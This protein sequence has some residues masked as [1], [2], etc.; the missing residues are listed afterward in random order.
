M[1]RGPKMALLQY[2]ASHRDRVCALL[3]AHGRALDSSD[4]GTG[5]TYVTA[6]VCAA[7]A[8]RPFVVCPKSVLPTWRQV[9]REFHVPPLGVTN[10]E[11]LQNCTMLD[12]EGGR[13]PCPWLAHY[14]A[15]RA[16]DHPGNTLTDHT[17]AWHDLPADALL[18]FDEAHR[19]K[20]H[21]T[22]SSVLLYT[23]AC[24]DARIL[25]LSA[26]IADKMD[27]FRMAGFVLRLYPAISHALNWMRHAEAANRGVP[28]RGVH[29]RLYP[30]RAARMRIQE[31]G[32]LFP[33]NQVVAQC[34][35]MDAAQEIEAQY[36]IIAHEVTRLR[37]REQAVQHELA[38]ILYARMR[39]EQ[40]KVPCMLELARQYLDEGNAVV[41][42]VNFANTLQVLAEQLGT[43]CTI[44]GDQ[45]L[46]ERQANIDQF[47]SDASHVIVCNIRSGGVG[48]SLH[49]T[50]GR[51]PRVSIINPSWS[52]QDLLQALGRVHRAN[53]R[54]PVRQ[55]IV[56]CANTVEEGVCARMREKVDNIVGLND[57][58]LGACPLNG[59]FG[60]ADADYPHDAPSHVERVAEAQLRLDGLRLQV[61]DAERELAALSAAA[62]MP[63]H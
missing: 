56:F 32:A 14:E 3:T 43:R 62:G 44:S 38:R 46:E 42:F 50:H 16:R 53:G 29:A 22:V 63:D 4:T 13:A 7:L 18:V 10:Y 59:L 8:L 26:T 2:Q 58:D 47:Q 28:M 45:T 27:T 23:A 57:G 40:L 33:R 9:L 30:E 21:R 25:L 41:L 35:D 17:Y 52:A 49:D 24:T 34:Y 15:P 5:K 61:A 37:G 54:T 36:A 31:L 12:A 60:D 6:A 1:P 48:V 39:I 51:Y 55:R 19:C 20:N 11:L